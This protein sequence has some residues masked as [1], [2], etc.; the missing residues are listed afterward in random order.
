MDKKK[1]YTYE[2]DIQIKKIYKR[3]IYIDKKYIRD[4]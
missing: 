4:I 3:N 2:R 1:T